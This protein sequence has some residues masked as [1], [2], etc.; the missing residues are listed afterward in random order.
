MYIH[1]GVL[2][3]SG[4][5]SLSSKPGSAEYRSVYKLAGA[6]EHFCRTVLIRL[7]RDRGSLLTAKRVC[8]G[9]IFFYSM[10]GFLSLILHLVASTKI[11][12]L[13]ETLLLLSL[14]NHTGKFYI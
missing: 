5:W 11:M 3:G 2:Q 10:E 7:D 9:F 8:L 12:T 13:T 6:K 4:T 1:D 14:S